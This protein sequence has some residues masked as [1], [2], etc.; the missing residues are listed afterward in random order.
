MLRVA[1]EAGAD[2]AGFVLVRQSPRFIA[3]GGE[4]PL[5]MLAGL[6]AAASRL[7]VRSV[8]L[9]ADPGHD[10]LEALAGDLR[11]D[12]VQL[13]GT[14]RPEFVAEIRAALPPSTEVWKALGVATPAD[15]EAASAY[16]AADRLL[17][18]AKPPTGATRTGGHGAAFDWSILEDWA[19]PKPWLL[20]G[21]LTEE[22]VAAAILETGAA[23]VDVSSGVERERGVKDAGLIRSFIAAAKNAGVPDRVSSS[24]ERD[25]S[26]SGDQT[27]KP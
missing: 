19:A 26:R 25:P 6:L 16:T 18:D 21:G 17:V 2:W 5:E 8:V 13:H 14:E 27:D 15:L 3:P 11:P 10:L 7:A 4:P 1:A 24:P 23:A 9:T 20:A 12:A 22:N